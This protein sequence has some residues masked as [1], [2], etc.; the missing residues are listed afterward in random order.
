MQPQIIITEVDEAGQTPAN[1]PCCQPQVPVLA[2]LLCSEPPTE[3]LMDSV[4]RENDPAGDENSVQSFYDKSLLHHT[5][6][7]D[8]LK[9]LE[10]TMVKP[11]NYFSD[12]NEILPYMRKVVASWMLE[13]SFVF[14]FYL[15]K[16][17]RV[18]CTKG[19][20][21][22]EREGATMFTWTTGCKGP[23]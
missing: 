7:I 10:S 20:L 12:K 14:W 21:R 18:D 2:E 19:E 23:A 6:V 11:V 5:N 22:I 4:V 1:L 17:S 16:I 15:V 9:F 13:V 3:D 8:S